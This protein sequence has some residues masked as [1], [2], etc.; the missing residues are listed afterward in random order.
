MNK[1]N[2]VDCQNTQT[3]R[4]NQSHSPAVHRT[5]LPTYSKIFN[6]KKQTGKKSTYSSLPRSNNTHFAANSLPKGIETTPVR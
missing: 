4:Q 5:Q 6:I 3:S 2:I 1:S